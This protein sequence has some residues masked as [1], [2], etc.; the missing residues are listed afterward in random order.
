MTS[1]I[2]TLMASHGVEVCS[3]KCPVMVKT[4]RML[5][6]DEMI[7]WDSKMDVHSGMY[8]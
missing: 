2:G 8:M 1:L 6:V 4:P 3:W 7:L 5:A